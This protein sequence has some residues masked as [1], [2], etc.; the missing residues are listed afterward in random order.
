MQ[1]R[2]AVDDAQFARSLVGVLAAP[3]IPGNQVTPL[4][5][6]DGFFSAM[7]QAIGSAERSV[8]LESYIYSSGRVGEAFADVLCARAKAG[9]P[10][11]V[12]LDWVGSRELG[13]DLLARMRGAGVHVALYHAPRWL[14]PAE[15]LRRS[16]R[17]V[18][19]VDGRIG[20]TGGMGMSDEWLGDADAPDRWRDMGA[21][22]EGPAVAAMQTAFLENWLEVTGEVLHGEAW[23]PEL[24]PMGPLAAQFVASSPEV[25]H[26]RARLLF[27]LV[28]AAARRNLRIATSYFV[29]DVA[30]VQALAAASRRGVRVEILLPGPID[31]PLAQRAS[32]SRWGPLLKAGCSIWEYQPSVFHSKLLVAD[33][34]F[35]SF[36]SM[37]V[38]SLSFRRNDE[39]NLNLLDE[40]TAARMIEVFEADKARSRQV[41][42][43]AWRRRPWIEKIKDGLAGLLRPWL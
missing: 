24:Q 34:R 2:E 14:R 43:D 26:P 22:V 36:G 38:D 42:P 18:L 10:V 40:A 39:A 37:N 5:N 16:H 21:Q 6:G 8:S 23:F 19:V 28:A 27:M 41:E 31:V 17:R 25:G 1:P 13:A 9:V 33:D 15:L 7:L 12:M 32:R 3:L 30:V 35:V 11:R 4:Q 29:P 20:F